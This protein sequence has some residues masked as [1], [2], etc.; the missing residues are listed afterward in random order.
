M[1]AYDA[2]I[3]GTMQDSASLPGSIGI[4]LRR[5]IKARAAH[6]QARNR[7]FS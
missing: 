3:G 5:W 2:H 7:E 6:R 4:A 1:T